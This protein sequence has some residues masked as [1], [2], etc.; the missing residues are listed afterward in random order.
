MPTETAPGSPPFGNTAHTYTHTQFPCASGNHLD[1]PFPLSRFPL[2]PP[3]PQVPATGSP[4]WRG[5]VHHRP[6]TD[7]MYRSPLFPILLRVFCFPD[8]PHT[9]LHPFSLTP[10]CED[11][12]SYGEGP[13]WSTAYAGCYGR[14][15]KRSSCPGLA[16]TTGEKGTKGKSR[17]QGRIGLP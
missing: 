16:W 5:F 11:I 2:W 15:G 6:K 1:V 10:Q 13:W 3:E 12:P 17:A 7:P 4:W 8:T 9:Y 14:N